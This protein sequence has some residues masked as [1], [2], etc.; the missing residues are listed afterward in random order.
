MSLSVFML[1]NSSLSLSTYFLEIPKMFQLPYLP[2]VFGQTGLCKGVD[3][4]PL[5]QQIIDTQQ[6]V[7]WTRSIFRTSMVSTEGARI[8]RIIK[9]YVF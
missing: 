6:L 8:V 4:L 1:R 7:K 9:V 2:K 3:C 5:I